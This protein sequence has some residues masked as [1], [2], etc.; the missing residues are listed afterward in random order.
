MVGSLFVVV[1]FVV[2]AAT[3]LGVALRAPDR[4]GMLL[5]V[6]ITSWIILQ[7]A[8]NIGAVVA[9]FPVVGITLP[10]LSFGG[11][12]LVTTMAAMGVLLNV[13]RQIR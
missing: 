3:G 6:G 11:T 1:L 9:V 13:A 2:I 5:A 12:S 8:L 7:A 4:F 10:L